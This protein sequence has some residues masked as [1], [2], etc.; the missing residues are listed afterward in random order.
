MNRNIQQVMSP[1]NAANVLEQEHHA[2]GWL[3]EKEI[4]FDSEYRGSPRAT[5]NPQG[6]KR[7]LEVVSAIESES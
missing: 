1:N 7:H 2:G 4:R 3:H 6:G 5:K